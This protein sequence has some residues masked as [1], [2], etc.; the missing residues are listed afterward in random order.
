M[1]RLVNPRRS[2]ARHRSCPTRSS[3]RAVTRFPSTELTIGALP[4]A[5]ALTRATAIAG[6]LVM[7]VLVLGATSIGHSNV[8]GDQLVH[9]L[10]LVGVIAFRGHHRYSVDR[11]LAGRRS[12]GG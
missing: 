1:P 9:A 12:T 3:R 11:L 10:F 7:I 6:G 4:L 8:I 5:G 2:I